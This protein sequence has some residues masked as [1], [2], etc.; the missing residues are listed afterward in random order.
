MK[1]ILLIVTSV[2]FG[3]SMLA[4]G[5]TF[6]QVQQERFALSADLEYRTRLLAESLNESIEPAYAKFATSTLT[7]LATSFANRERLVGVAIFEGTGATIVSSEGMPS[8]IERSMKVMDQAIETNEPAGDY[9]DFSSRQYYVLAR[10]LHRGEDSSGVFVVVQDAAYIAESV[11][12]KWKENLVGVLVYL[13]LFAAAI[14]ALVRWVIFM[15]LSNLAESIRS[16]RSGKSPYLSESKHDFFFRP[17]AAEI[18][19]LAQSLMQ[20]RSAASEEARMRLEKIDSP[21]TAERLKAFIASYIKDRPIF[22]I[23]HSEPYIHRHVGR[24]VDYVVPAGGVVTAVSSVM[25]ACGGTWLAYGGGDA[26]RE[27]ADASGKIRVP[28]DEPRYTL[29]RVWLT[30]AEMQGYYR[31][32]SNESLWPLCHIA[33]TRPIFRKEDWTIY[34]KVNGTF[35]ETL[36]SEIRNIERP[37]ILV[38][39]YHFAL[40]PRMIKASRPDAQVLLFWHIPWPSP[41]SFSICPWRKEILEGMLGADIIGFHTQQFCNNFLETVGKEIESL[42]DLEHFSI[43]HDEHVSFVK[44][45]PVSIAFTDAQQGIERKEVLDRAALGRLRISSKFLILGV[46]RL[47]YTKGILERLKSIEFLLAEHPEYQK[48]ITFLQIASPTREGVEK[49]REYAEAVQAE[50]DR[51]NERF[52]MKGWQPI[53]LE[54]KHYSH[55]EL[56]PLYKLADVCLVTSVHDGMNL[57]AKEFVAARNDEAGVLVLSQFAGASRDLKG[58]LIVNPYSA[59]DT[60]EAIHT[61]LHMSPVEQHRRMKTMRNSVRD[62]NVYRWAAELIKAVSGL[63]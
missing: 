56:A 3:A 50:T 54:H 24:G 41:E 42:I 1:H 18:G 29:K 52:K 22:V 31:G 27:T 36:L 6:L 10:P 7:K 63:K 26:D 59:E 51:I 15:P 17:L 11:Q 39:D 32:F 44:P 21:W 5:F 48:K 57:V 35:A 25:E 38:Q 61:A 60:A 30:E 19:K 55:E 34:K 33:H 20:A 4:L 53:V 45:F 47:D 23:S 13:L 43:T 9:F 12:G 8:G 14:A 62:Y 40:L 49:Y 46:D 28:P 58:A 37:I 16:A 2:I